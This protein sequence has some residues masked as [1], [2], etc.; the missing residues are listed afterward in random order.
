MPPQ[1]ALVM[2]V[3]GMT[4]NNCVNHVQKAL[5]TAP[6]VTSAVVDLKKGIAEVKGTGLAHSRLA[7]PVKQAGYELKELAPEEAQKLASGKSGWAFWRR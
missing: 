1:E 3:T 7:E 4:C 6:G 2:R 5:L